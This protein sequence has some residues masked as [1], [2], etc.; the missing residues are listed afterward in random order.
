MQNVETMRSA[1]T[2]TLDTKTNQVVLIAAEFTPPPTP[3]PAGER[4]GRGQI[5]TGFLFNSRGGRHGLMARRVP[6]FRNGAKGL[7]SAKLGWRICSVG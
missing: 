4:R 7:E 6:N 5:G 3:P 2:L 1:K